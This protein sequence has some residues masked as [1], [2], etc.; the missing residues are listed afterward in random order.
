MVAP[1]GVAFDRN[2]YYSA[3]GANPFR[4][5][6]SNMT[7]SPWSTATGDATSLYQQTTFSDPVRSFER[8]CESITGQDETFESAASMVR[9]QSRLNWDSRMTARSLRAYFASGFEDSN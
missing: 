9:G 4:L 2:R 5:M 6:G 3:A 7:F 1:T 8:Y